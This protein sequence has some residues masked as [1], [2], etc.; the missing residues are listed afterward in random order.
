LQV[1]S[2]QITEFG[3]DSKGLICRGGR[4]KGVVLQD[5]GS[6]E[7]KYLLGKG[8]FLKASPRPERKWKGVGGGGGGGEG[9][10]GGWGGGGGGGG[11]SENSTK[12]GEG[13]THLPTLGGENLEGRGKKHKLRFPHLPVKNLKRQELKEKLTAIQ[14]EKK[15]S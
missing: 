6:W 3:G 5:R 4:I 12:E 2:R 8:S 9:G 11:C 14:R 15:E 10:G 7:R 13:T 1:T